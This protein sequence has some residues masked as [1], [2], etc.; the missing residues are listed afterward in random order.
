MVTIIAVIQ[1]LALWVKAVTSVKL[2][3]IAYLAKKI[4]LPVLDRHPAAIGRSQMPRVQKG[5]EMRD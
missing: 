3:H 4:S 5:S 1:G 2:S